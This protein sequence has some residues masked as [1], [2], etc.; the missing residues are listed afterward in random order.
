[1]QWES[2]QRRITCK[3]SAAKQLTSS[4]GS[5]PCDAMWLIKWN[6]EAPLKWLKMY[7]GFLSPVSVI[8]L[9]WYMPYV[10]IR[11]ICNRFSEEMISH[12]FIGYKDVRRVSLL[13]FPIGIWNVEGF[14]TWCDILFHIFTFTNVLFLSEHCRISITLNVSN[15]FWEFKILNPFLLLGIPLYLGIQKFPRR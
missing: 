10:I 3:W 4:K 6:E 11:R 7:V 14:F 5:Q 8:G 2:L 12:P 1:M 9:Y 15:D 13:E